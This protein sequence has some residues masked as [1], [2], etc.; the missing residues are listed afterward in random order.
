METCPA[1]PRDGGPEMIDLAVEH[2][3]GLHLGHPDGVL[4]RE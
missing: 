1:Q 2:L 3:D 4:A